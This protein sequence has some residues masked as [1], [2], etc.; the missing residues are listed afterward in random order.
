LSWTRT[1]PLS[2]TLTQTP[3]RPL[4][5]CVI[6]GS[7]NLSAPAD[8]AQPHV[9]EGCPA[10]PEPPPVQVPE[11][12]ATEDDVASVLA[13]A[14]A[15]V[16]LW[17]EVLCRYQGN[18]RV[19]RRPAAHQSWHEGTE[20]SRMQAMAGPG[21]TTGPTSLPRGHGLRV[22]LPLGHRRSRFRLPRVEENAK[23]NFVARSAGLEP[24][25]F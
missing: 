16:H 18:L 7:V 19:R 5:D 6:P 14:D 13:V 4:S 3:P 10:A 8:R 12:Y 15:D 25:T 11:V 22:R 9:L 24:A 17:V 23:G 20:Q 2:T 21:F 1:G